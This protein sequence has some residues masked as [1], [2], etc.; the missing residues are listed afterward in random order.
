MN[1]FVE[2]TLDERGEP[3]VVPND[4]TTGRPRFHDLSPPPRALEDGS[5]SIVTAKNGVIAENE[6]GQIVVRTRMIPDFAR[7]P[8]YAAVAD[9]VAPWKYAEQVFVFDRLED[10]RSYDW[11]FALDDLFVGELAERSTAGGERVR[12]VQAKIVARDDSFREFYRPSSIDPAG[13]RGFGPGTRPVRI[14][15]REDRL[16]ASDGKGGSERCF[17]VVP[18]ADL[19]SFP[20]AEG[21][22]AYLTFDH[23]LRSLRDVRDGVVIPKRVYT[24]SARLWDPTLTRIQLVYGHLLQPRT[25]HERGRTGVLDLHHVYPMGLTISERRGRPVVRVYCG[26]ADAHTTSYDVDL[27]QLL[28]EMSAGSRRRALGQVYSPRA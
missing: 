8:E 15:R 1:R 22:V 27:M 11:R 17:G 2:L 28:L 6:L 14:E 24:A 19:A 18:E 10:F 13:P 26:A 12:P 5:W 7:S 23:E 9:R 25:A 16:F 20:L 4:P 21:A 3:E